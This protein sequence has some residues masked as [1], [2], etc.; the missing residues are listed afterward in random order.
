VEENLL[1]S[2][3]CFR[4][5]RASAVNVPFR[6]GPDMGDTVYVPAFASLTDDLL[7]RFQPD[8]VVFQV[9]ARVFAWALL[10]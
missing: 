10:Y 5:G 9:L 6:H 3:S 1:Q 2:R 7:Q 4:R 8:V